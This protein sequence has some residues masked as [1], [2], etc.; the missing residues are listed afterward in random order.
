M[1]LVVPG[2]ERVNRNFLQERVGRFVS[3]GDCRNVY[4]KFIPD[5]FQILLGFPDVVLMGYTL[6]RLRDAPPR[7]F[8]PLLLFAGI[9]L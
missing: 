8:V 1:H 2:Y 3:Q 7:F 6:K 5:A 4:L 9:E